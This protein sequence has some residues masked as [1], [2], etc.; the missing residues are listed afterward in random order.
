[1]YNDDSFEDNTGLLEVRR[2]GSE[3][4]SVCDDSFNDASANVACRW[5]GYESATSWSAAG[6]TFT[7]LVI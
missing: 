1:M 2:D 3:W 5:L 4:G 7:R 6:G